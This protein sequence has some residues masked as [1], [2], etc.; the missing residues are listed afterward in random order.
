MKCKAVAFAFAAFLGA[1]YYACA[2]DSVSFAPPKSPSGGTPEIIG[3]KPVEPSEW[4]ATVIISSGSI[5]C[6]A[7][8]V[9]PE[10]LLT[11]AHCLEAAGQVSVSLAGQQV[12]GTC[13]KHPHYSP[14]NPSPDFG[15]C[16]LDSPVTDIIFERIGTSIAISRVGTAVT[17]L[18]YGCTLAGGF[19]HQFGVLHVGTATVSSLPQGANLDTVVV[20][21][22]AVCFGDSGGAAYVSERPD[23]GSRAIFGVNSR[24]DIQKTTYVSS[25]DTTSFIDWAFAWSATNAVRVCGLFADVTGCHF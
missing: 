5:G 11:A 7:T 25:T 24:G 17:L 23:G 13:T 8:L 20:G 21:D 12:G 2:Q 9:G 4:P 16:K 22:A 1:T 3:A 10:V 15:L 14:S 18:G 19:D 6:T